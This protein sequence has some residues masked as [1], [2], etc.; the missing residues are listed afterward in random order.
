MN[1]YF[2]KF[3]LKNNITDEIELYKYLENKDNLQNS[4]F[5]SLPTIFNKTML[6]AIVYQEA[7]N[8]I[9]NNDSYNILINKLEKTTIINIK[10]KD[11]DICYK[12]WFANKSEKNIF[13]DEFIYD[14]VSTMSIK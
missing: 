14:L 10:E 4:I 12:I 7:E 6:L 9:V 8:I 1:N 5:D 3:F 2:K 13:N 11:S